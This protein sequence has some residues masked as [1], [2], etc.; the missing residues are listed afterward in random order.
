M[1]SSEDLEMFYLD[2]QSECVP[3]GMKLQSY[4]SR[5]NV[6]YKEM[7]SYSRKTE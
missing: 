3:L 2:Y 5:N 4:R 1:Y 7:E 6:P